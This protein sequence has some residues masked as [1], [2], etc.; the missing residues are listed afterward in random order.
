MLKKL[1]CG[2]VRQK[3]CF[4]VHADSNLFVEP[5]VGWGNFVY[6]TEQTSLVR[7]A[8]SKNMMHL[9]LLN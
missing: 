3:M 4:Q 1:I 5:S 9:D 6:Y 2:M 7:T 8:A